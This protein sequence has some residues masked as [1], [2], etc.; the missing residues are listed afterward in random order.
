MNSIDWEAR[1]ARQLVRRLY[2]QYALDAEIAD[3]QAE[4]AAR[5]APLRTPDPRP[6]VEG[7]RR[8][9]LGQ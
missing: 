2:A 8:G 4:D 7:A 5:R 6:Q 3:L 1:Q 9:A